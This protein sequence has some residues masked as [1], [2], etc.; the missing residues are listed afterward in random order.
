MVGF[1]RS[2][3]YEVFTSSINALMVYKMVHFIL[4]GCKMQVKSPASGHKKAEP[5]GPASLSLPFQISLIRVV[6]ALS[7]MDSAASFQMR[8][9]SSS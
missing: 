9:S 8:L 6:A 4:H 5:Q 2:M 3:S 7:L 1:C